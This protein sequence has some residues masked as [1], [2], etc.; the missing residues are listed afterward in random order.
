MIGLRIG[1]LKPR[2]VLLR[3]LFHR[4][5]TMIGATSLLIVVGLTL[6]AFVVASIS[7]GEAHLKHIKE[8]WVQYRCNPLYMPLADAV[9]SDILSNFMGCTMSA[10]QTYAGYALDPI[11]S[12]FHSVGGILSDIQGTLDD[13]RDMISGTKNA[14]L[15]IIGDVYGKLQNTFSET[16]R[17][18]AR[19]R[20][21][22]HRILA[23][24]VTIFHMVSTGVQTGE[25]VANGP[26]GQAAQFFC[27]SPYTQ[28]VLESGVGICIQKV[29]LGDV[30]KGGAV[31][32]SILL[33]DG[34]GVPMY[35]M[36]NTL[37]SGNHKVQYQGKWIRVEHHPHAVKTDAQY[38]TLWC[39]NTSTNTI[40]IGEYVFKDYEETQNPEVLGKFEQ[41]VETLHNATL[42]PENAKRRR[43]PLEYRYS[44]T[45]PDTFVKMEDQSL[46]SIYNVRVGDRVAKGGKVLGLVKH[47]Q[48]RDPVIAP[49]GTLLSKGTWVVDSRANNVLTADAAYE[50]AFVDP[51]TKLFCVN[52]L[53][54][55]GYVTLSDGKHDCVIL[56]DQETTDE[57]VHAW[58]DTAIQKETPA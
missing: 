54:E 25:S 2:F 44:G 18:I 39:L 49:T 51:S 1:L 13:F 40:P 27:F 21:L 34:A 48:L 46:K 3:L 14:F 45:T 31:V 47:R 10:F 36:G 16:T 41:I 9:G 52:L 29:K 33:L 11:Y 20:T 15:S 57:W 55:N 32:E 8:N 12:M 30:L 37:V 53:T 7:Y 50:R 28:L 43:N 17:L 5:K 58:R 42:L 6:L 22:T 4:S 38:G 35:R 26:I 23:I 19:I 56:D 24:F